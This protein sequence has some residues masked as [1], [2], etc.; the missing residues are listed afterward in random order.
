MLTALCLTPLGLRCK[1]TEVFLIKQTDFI[2]EVIDGI[3]RRGET[4]KE[5]TS[6][7]IRSSLC[8]N[9]LLMSHEPIVAPYIYYCAKGA[10]EG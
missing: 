3:Y 9:L 10:G 1:V 2:Y 5:R 8:Y 7:L 4:K 6:G